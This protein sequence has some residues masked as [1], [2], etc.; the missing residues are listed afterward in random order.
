MDFMLKY[1]L[2]FDSSFTPRHF[3]LSNAVLVNKGDCG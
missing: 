3:K 1:M 2:N